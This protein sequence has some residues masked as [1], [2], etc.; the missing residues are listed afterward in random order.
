M[1]HKAPAQ[2]VSCPVLCLQWYCTVSTADQYLCSSRHQW[3]LAPSARH[4]QTQGTS[5]G[6]VL[7]HPNET[8][9]LLDGDGTTIMTSSSC[10]VNLQEPVW[11]RLRSPGSA[12][13]GH[14]SSS[15]YYFGLPC[16]GV[17]P[18]MGVFLLVWSGQ[19]WLGLSGHP[20]S[21]PLGMTGLPAAVIR[22]TA[23]RNQMSP[24][25][26]QLIS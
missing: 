15:Y 6:C 1:R 9:P 12:G 18:R 23:F 10:D 19:V 14:S 22:M 20:P 8:R 25:K 5:C 17:I 2:H 26:K 7:L 4:Q 13:V 11:G 3:Y 21:L 16:A 24:C